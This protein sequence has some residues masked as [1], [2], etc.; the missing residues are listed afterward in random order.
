MSVTDQAYV[1][2]ATNDVYCQ[3]ALVL[4]QSLRNHGATRRLVVLITPQVSHLLR[5][6]LSR[7]FDEVVEVN[8]LDSVDSGHLALLRRPELSVTLTKLHCWTLTQ[9][10]KGV[11]LDADTLVLSNVDEL[12]ERSE[13]SAAPDPGWPDCFNSG[14]F[15]FRPSLDTHGRLLQHAAQHGSFDGADQGV[16]NSFFGT[17]PTAD[18]R[19]HLPFIYNLSSSTAYTY[20]PA[21]KQFGAHA[22]VVHFLGPQ[23]PW[24]FDFRR[25]TGAVAE[26]GPGRDPPPQVPFLNVWWSIYQRSVLPALQGLLSLDPPEP[27]G[28]PVDP[29]GVVG[30]QGAD[31]RSPTGAA[32]LP[33]PPVGG[34]PEETPVLDEP[35][36]CPN[37]QPRE[38][39]PLHPELHPEETRGPGEPGG[40]Q[41]PGQEPPV[42]SAQDPAPQGALEVDLVVS[43]S[44]TSIQE[45]VREPSPE[46]ERRMWE[47]G[48]IDYL[49]KDAFSRIQEKLDR[50]LQ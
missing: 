24:H 44:E 27:P 43:A 40:S 7:V 12:F 2:L 3:G 22:K 29:A 39:Q 34:P 6:V 20:H 36:P 16:L 46:E 30:E 37:G 15:V 45:K 49:G 48:R 42:E 11:F 28:P 19:K 8:L 50:F 33:P 38:D 47:D 9:Y 25:H 10:S 17:W 23:K 26:S 41:G 14:V 35:L 32:D 4:G 18:I 1:T 5:A 31:C 13:L 21:F